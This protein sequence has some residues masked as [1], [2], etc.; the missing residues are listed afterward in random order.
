VR[1][2]DDEGNQ[3]GVVDT[4]VAL[5]MAREKG[6]DLVEVAPEA[7]PPVCKILDFGKHKYLIKKKEHQARRKQ[8]HVVV[9]EMRVR[10]KIDTHDLETKL[11]KARHFLLEGDKLQVNML[12]R[13]R[14]MGFKDLGMSKMQAIKEALSDISKVEREPRQEGNRMIMILQPTAAKG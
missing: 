12:F 6:M 3:R 11:K 13:G 14:E 8:H 7:H 5:D 10:P 4:E 9:K 1:L 2:I